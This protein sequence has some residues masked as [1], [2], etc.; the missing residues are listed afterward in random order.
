MARGDHVILRTQFFLSDNLENRF[1]FQKPAPYTS[2]CD[3]WWIQDFPEGDIN[4]QVD[5][6]LQFFFAE[7]CMKMNEFGPRGRAPRGSANADDPSI[8]IML[9][10]YQGNELVRGRQP[11]S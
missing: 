8:N 1:Q 7:N 3:Q 6:I 11:Y 10:M 9:F 2:L 4:S 5:V